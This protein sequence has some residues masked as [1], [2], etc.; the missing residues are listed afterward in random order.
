MTRNMFGVTLNLTQLQLQ[1]KVKIIRTVLCCT[2]VWHSC[3]HAVFC[4]SYS[5]L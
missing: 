4:I 3:K 1:D 5:P 2:A